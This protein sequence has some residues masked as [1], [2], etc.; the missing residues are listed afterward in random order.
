MKHITLE[1]GRILTPPKELQPMLKGAYSAFFKIL[2]HIRFF[3][4]ADEV[5]DG[6]KSLIFN[7]CGEQLA[8]FTLD[9]GV[10]HINIIEDVFRIVDE[11]VL[12]DVFG[13]LKKAAS[14]NQR[15]PFE[16]LTVDL[17]EYPSGIRCDLC[18][19]EKRH[20]ENDFE[21]SRKFAIM[22][23]HCYYGVEEGWG[24]GVF[25]PSYCEGKQG[26]YTKTFA[27]LEKKNFT[28]C[29][30]CGDYHTCGDCGVGHNPGECNM[31]ITAE[32]VTNL[33]IPYCETE[34]LDLFKNKD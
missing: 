1:D 28:N 12:D 13:K 21:G 15:R 27:C 9:D 19:L 8:A 11:S 33:I 10:F 20:N 14:I 3:Y 32:E 24:E 4:V 18:L 25:S 7:S 2:G 22:D 17:D 16:Q 6:K 26:C 29:L 30:Q 5:W 31:G 23:H 34:R